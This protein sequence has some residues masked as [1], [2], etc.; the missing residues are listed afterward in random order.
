MKESAMTETDKER[1]LILQDN[2]LEQQ[3][4]IQSLYNRI[5]VLNE[6][7]N[8]LVEQLNLLRVNHEIM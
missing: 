2:I 7:K 4:E 6:E 1:I 3:K 5:I 8:A